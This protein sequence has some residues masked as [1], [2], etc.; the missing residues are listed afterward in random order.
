MGGRQAVLHAV[1]VDVVLIACARAVLEHAELRAGICRP[2]P[3]AL[4]IGNFAPTANK[5]LYMHAHKYFINFECVKY[6]QVYT[7]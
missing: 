7:R 4:L 5:T 3:A 6:P 1:T 2:G